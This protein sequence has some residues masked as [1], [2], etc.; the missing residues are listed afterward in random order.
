MIDRTA[1]M[2]QPIGH[3]EIADLEHTIV[4]RSLLKRSL[5]QGDLRGLALHQQYGPPT[6]PMHENICPFRQP[7]QGKWDLHPHHGDRAL[8]VLQKQVD[9]MLAHPFLGCKRHPAPAHR[10][11]HDRSTGIVLSF[12][13]MVRQV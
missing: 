11:E 10:I 4:T 13:T 3:Q 8:K 6:F 1:V 7:V 9:H 12:D 5:R 2:F